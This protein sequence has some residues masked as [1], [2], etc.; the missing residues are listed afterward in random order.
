MMSKNF[1]KSLA[2]AVRRPG[3]WVRF[4]QYPI[5][6]NY[7]EFKRIALKPKLAHR[8][9]YYL[10]NKNM[11]TTILIPEEKGYASYGPETTNRLS[12]NLIKWCESIAAEKIKN[13]S[14]DQKHN[15]NYLIN[16]LEDEELNVNNEAFQIATHPEIVATVTKYLD[17]YPLLT[18]I[19]LWYTPANS[20]TMM[21]GS[22]LF[23]L[24]HEDFK[25]VKAFVYLNDMN[26]DSGVQMVVD[27]DKSLDLQ[28]KINYKM[29]EDSKR[30]PDE[31]IEPYNPKQLD[32]KKGSLIL[33]DT[34]SCFHAGGRTQ[35]NDRLLL[36][37][38]YVTPYRHAKTKHTKK[39]EDFSGSVKNKDL[40]HLLK[41]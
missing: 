23:H 40:K 21:T 16:L 27:A 37:F 32:A 38:Q 4:Q 28:N 29:T 15:K 14:D 12:P 18:Y 6:K 9:P 1:V 39:Y 30:V 26:K 13:L 34:S 25:Q 22:Q 36:T 2:Q 24:D 5:R 7:H 8:Q 17:A 11:K 19:G 41:T 31:V 3:S 35:K 20:E 33:M 10:K